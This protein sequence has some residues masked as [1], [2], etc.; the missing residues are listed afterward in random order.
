MQKHPKKI[1]TLVSGTIIQPYNNGFLQKKSALSLTIE[2]LKQEIVE[3][4]IRSKEFLQLVKEKNENYN[5]TKKD[6]IYV[7]IYDDW[8]YDKK[9][10]LLKTKNKKWVNNFINEEAKTFTTNKLTKHVCCRWSYKNK[11]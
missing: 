8:Y 6:F 9:A 5:L 11:C 10:E 2:E 1:K 7:E 3:Q 4:F